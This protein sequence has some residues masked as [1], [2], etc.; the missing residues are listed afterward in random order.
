MVILQ[1]F[2]GS[3][4]TFTYLL[5]DAKTKDAVIIDPVIEQVERDVRLVQDMGLNL[6][7]AC[8]FNWSLVTDL[9][10][11]LIAGFLLNCPKTQLCFTE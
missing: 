2:D 6:L 8:E 11:I 4:F 7:Y 5:A 3:S 9:I 1:L 10:V